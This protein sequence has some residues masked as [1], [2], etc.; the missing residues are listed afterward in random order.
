M[1]KIPMAKRIPHPHEIHGDIREDDYY[2][3]RDR[4]NPEVISYLEQENDYYRTVSQAYSELTQSLYEQMVARIPEQESRVPVQLGQYFYYT[5]LEKS[6]QYPIYARKRAASR[7]ELKHAAEEVMLDLNEMARPGE[8]LSVTEQRVSP[9]GTR[10]AYLENRDGTDL[11]TLKV[12]DLATGETLS[13]TVDNVYLAGSI[14]WDSSGTY[15]FYVT[16]DDS[17]RPYR[18]WRY[19]VGQPQAAEM[20]YEETDQTFVLQLAKSR[21]GK[22]LFAVS[23]ATMTSEVRYLDA[24][25]P[26]DDFTVFDPRERGVEYVVE[27]WRDEF[28]ILTNRNALN[29]RVERCR[30]DSIRAQQREDLIPHEESRY[31]VALYPFRDALLIEGREA[32]LTQVWI[33]RDGALTQLTWDEP[34]YTVGVGN[35]L[36]YDTAEALIEFESFVTPLTT[37]AVDLATGARTTLQ[38]QQ[39]S[40]AYHPED[41][42]QERL[43]IAARDGVKVPA[44]AVYR[45]GA[46][47]RGPAPLLLYGYGSY[48]SCTDP[49]FQ[50]LRLPMLDAGVVYVIAQV[51]GGSELGRG[52]YEDGKLLKKRNTFT[53]FIDVAKDLIE[54]GYTTS[55][56][57]AADGRSAGGLLMGA[58]A[59]MGGEYF[60]AI[61][62]GVPFVDVMT[63]MLDA[64]I[65][66]TTL[67]WDEWGNPAEPEYYAYMRSYSP[68]DNVEA[69]AYPHMLVTTG[70]NDPRVAYWEPA[71]WVARLRQVKTDDHSLLLKTNMGAGHSGASG[72]LDKIREQAEIY[73]FLLDKI[74]VHSLG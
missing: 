46:L 15:L 68:Y 49:H 52:W 56:Q 51:R 59:N 43:W 21:S 53:D 22:Y 44:A 40:G 58:V 31:L 57:L 14:E 71:K 72:R 11:Y 47:D 13:D 23:S 69:K 27:H 8:F 41:Y 19:P 34:L 32:G 42:V 64:S 29:F 55:S 30:T 24:S 39:V 16:A 4:S 28:V 5:R 33:Y 37:F 60:Q 10:L 6:L 62:A 35:N 9:D 1:G 25:R 74:G 18:L 3:L 45:R 50:P 70:L 36:S 67:E 26:L 66:L 7:S 12:K 65:P 20:L 63:T 17:Q 48:G 2:W 54:R 73:A 38:V 61:H